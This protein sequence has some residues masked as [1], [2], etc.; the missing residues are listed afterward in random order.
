MSTLPAPTRPGPARSR[1]AGAP[2]AP[3]GRSY[4]VRQS[5]APTRHPDRV[6]TTNVAPSL[7]TTPS[8]PAEVSGDA[9]TAGVS[10][11]TRELLRRSRRIRPARPV[12]C[13]A[14]NRASEQRPPSRH[15]RLRAS[16]VVWQRARSKLSSGLPG[17]AG[18][19]PF[20]AEI[21]ARQQ[22]SSRRIWRA[23]RLPIEAGTRAQCAGTERSPAFVGR[24]FPSVGSAV[25]F[26][27]WRGVSIWWRGIPLARWWRRTVVG[28][29]GT[30]R[31]ERIGRHFELRSSAGDRR[32]LPSGGRN[33]NRD[34][35]HLCLCR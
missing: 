5:R 25:R 32:A 3:D 17:C 12:S 35:G 11:D 21:G 20:H 9:V 6:R 7:D 4:L 30:A 16:V 15:R 14:A 27:R 23:G 18:A 24:S 10:G 31:R 28:T 13:R 33:G 22:R 1:D 19:R 8:T 2:A 26:V 34:R 29:R